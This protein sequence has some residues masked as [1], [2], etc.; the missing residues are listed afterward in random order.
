MALHLRLWLGLWFEGHGHGRA[1]THTHTGRMHGRAAAAAGVACVPGCAPRWLRHAMLHLRAGALASVPGPNVQWQRRGGGGPG[2]AKGIGKAG[3][4]PLMCDAA[5]RSPPLPHPLGRRQTPGAS[6]CY[7]YCQYL[8]SPALQSRAQP[9]PALPC[10]APP[11]QVRHDVG[12][13]DSHQH[14]AQR[15]GQQPAEQVSRPPPWSPRP[16]T[17]THA[18]TI[19][20]RARTPTRTPQPGLWG[21]AWWRWWW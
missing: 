17:L 13:Q 10:P 14:G 20:V 5:A 11:R 15:V 3:R 7:G 9:C 18:P 16:C 12:R 2:L 21:R 1:H 8:A 6:R 19:R 4:V